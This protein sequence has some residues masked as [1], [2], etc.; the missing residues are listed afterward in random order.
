MTIK[1]G[2][3]VISGVAFKAGGWGGGGGRDIQYF[4]EGG[5]TLYGWELSILWRDLITP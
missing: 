3:T 2:N 1:L 5:R 4:W